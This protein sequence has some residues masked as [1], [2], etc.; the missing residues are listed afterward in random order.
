MELGWHSRP[1]AERL[2]PATL[3]MLIT[4][5]EHSIFAQGVTWNVDSFGP[6]CVE[7]GRV[8]VGR[9]LPERDTKTESNGGHDNSIIGLIRRYRMLKRGNDA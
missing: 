4:L 5:Y 7:L 3:G 9:I 8:L 2:M 1:A 6:W